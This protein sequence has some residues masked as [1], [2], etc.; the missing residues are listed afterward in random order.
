[1]RT[2]NKATT[3]RAIEKVSMEQ[4]THLILALTGLIHALTQFLQL[5]I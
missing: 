5:F 1:M 4:V 2:R 3:S